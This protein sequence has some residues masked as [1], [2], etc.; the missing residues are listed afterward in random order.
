MNRSPL[1]YD[2]CVEHNLLR[3]QCIPAG[4]ESLALLGRDSPLKFMAWLK[5]DV[6]LAAVSVAETS[7]PCHPAV[8][9]DA[10]VK[11]RIANTANHR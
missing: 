3:R 1:M 11:W 8:T 5:H 7:L 9:N 10:T 4:G 6:M 2:V